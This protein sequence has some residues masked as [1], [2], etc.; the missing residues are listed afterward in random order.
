MGE[1]PDLIAVQ[2]TIVDTFNEEGS[3][4]NVSAEKAVC[5]HGAESQRNMMES[6]LERKS[7]AGNGA[8]AKEKDH[9]QCWEGYF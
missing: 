9:S 2:E 7:V 4:Q 3:L 5:F 1:T 8:Q 6:L